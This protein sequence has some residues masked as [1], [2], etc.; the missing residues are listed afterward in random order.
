MPLSTALFILVAVTT[1]VASPEEAAKQGLLCL[2]LDATSLRVNVEE[3]KP[4]QLKAAVEANERRRLYIWSR[5]DGSAVHA[6]FTDDSVAAEA[7]SVRL[8]I[9]SSSRAWPVDTELVVRAASGETWRWTAGSSDIAR[10]RSIT[11][12]HG[13][14]ELSVSAGGHDPLVVPIRAERQIALGTI[15]LIPVPVITG[16]VV[17]RSTSAGL[18]GAV[19]AT[20]SGET[21]ALTDYDGRFSVALPSNPQP[22]WLA[23]SYGGYGNRSVPVPKTRADAALPPISLAHAGQIEVTIERDLE[24]Y[25]NIAVSLSRKEGRKQTAVRESSL[26]RDTVD[27]TFKDLDEGEYVVTLRGSEPQQRLSEVVEVRA[28][29]TVN[30]RMAIEPIEL[31]GTVTRGSKRIADATLTLKASPAGWTTTIAG[32]DRG[33]FEEELWQAGR[34]LVSVAA[35]ELRSPYAFMEQLT[36]VGNRI[37]WA[38]AIPAG[39]ITGTVTDGKSRRPV[40]NANVTLDSEITSRGLT[41]SLGATTDNAGRFTFEGVAAGDHAVTVEARGFALHRGSSFRFVGDEESR[42]LQIALTP[43]DQRSVDVTD[44]Q[45]RPLSGATVVVEGALLATPSVTD[46]AGRATINAEP[47]QRPLL[48]AFPRTGSFGLA[49]VPEAREEPV[50]VIVGPPSGSLMIHTLHN[51]SGE[52]LGA[53]RILL[54]YNGEFISPHLMEAAER[55]GVLKGTTDQAGVLYMPAL[56][57]GTYELWPYATSAEGQQILRGAVRAAATVGISHGEYTVRLKFARSTPRG[58]KPSSKEAR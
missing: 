27:A 33:T 18:A 31:T 35:S 24:R 42:S 37:R 43:A 38:V 25:P 34:F 19:I 15:H 51:D 49:R 55:L 4:A 32:T 30:V 28:G 16:R 10:L 26:D 17:D 36:P 13:S 47:G 3:C 29:D 14:Y 7:T 8:R 20:P 53:I 50:R 58:D 1:L 46:A 5:S 22:E 21:L 12:P 39:I 44:L 9:E 48:F 40:Q 52:P 23:V 57:A 41:S 6:G 56:P 45:N 54:R 2:G 11:L